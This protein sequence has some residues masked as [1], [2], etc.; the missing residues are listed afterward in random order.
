MKWLAVISRV[1]FGAFTGTLV[2]IA[3]GP[4]LMLLALAVVD[5]LFLPIGG[6]WRN[7][8]Q[9]ASLTMIPIGSFGGACVGFASRNK[10]WDE[11]P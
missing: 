6:A 2:G 9:F 5:S 1:M 11:L 10:S 8:L 7:Y 3:C 4:I